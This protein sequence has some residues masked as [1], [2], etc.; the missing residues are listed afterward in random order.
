M[1]PAVVANGIF[2]LL[3]KKI[4]GIFFG[5]ERENEESDV[6]PT[7]GIRIA[8]IGKDPLILI[9]PGSFCPVPAMMRLLKAL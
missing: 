7:K 2:L 3:L 9:V 6:T 5:M 1:N 4:R 8:P